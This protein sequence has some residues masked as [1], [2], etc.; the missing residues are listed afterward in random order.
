M[1]NRTV[2]WAPFFDDGGENTPHSCNDLLQISS[3]IPSYEQWSTK[4]QLPALSKLQQNKSLAADSVERFG[5]TSDSWFTQAIA[6]NARL[7][8]FPF[9]PEKIDDQDETIKIQKKLYKQGADFLYGMLF[10]E[11]VQLADSV[12]NH[13]PPSGSKEDPDSLTIALD[14]WKNDNDKLPET[15]CLDEI[16]SSAN[17][18]A[19]KHGC[20]VFIMSESSTT[21]DDLQNWLSNR[22]CSTWTIASSSDASLPDENENADFFRNLILAS[23]ARTAL[24][25]REGMTSS[26]LLVSRIEYK[27]QQEIWRLGR[28]PPLIPKLQSCFMGA[29]D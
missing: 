19:E 11:T 8:I 24:V 27:R 16:L 18:T 5:Q 10:K 14:D 17:S 2:L 9:L 15:D 20:N 23:R 22:N 3:W 25:G 7:A 4:L 1:T 21:N 13:V 28:D 6:S 26:E 12:R 29:A